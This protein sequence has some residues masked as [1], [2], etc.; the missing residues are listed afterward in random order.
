[1]PAAESLPLLPLR[2][3][4]LFPHVATPLAVGREGSRA[5]IAMASAAPGRNLVVALQRSPESDPAVLADLYRIATRAVLR[6]VQGGDGE[7]VTVIVQGMERVLLTGLEHEDGALMVNAVPRPLIERD[8]NSVEALRQEIREL[9]QRVVTL[10]HGDQARDLTQLMNWDAEARQLVYMLATVLTLEPTE[11]Q[12]LLE[13]D[14]VGTAMHWVHTHLAHEVQIL[15]IRRQIAEQTAGELSKE[16]REGILRRQLRTIQSQLGEDSPE[17]LEIAAL[18]ERIEQADLPA[19]V[20]RE[21]ERELSRLEH[22]SA[23]AAEYPMARTYI[24]LVAALPWS[25]SEQAPVDLAE[26]RRILD[27]DH[28]GLG[29]V[30]QRILEHLAVLRLNPSAKG[31]ILCLIGPPGVGKTSL[32]HSIARATGRVFERLS[33]G[34]VHDEAELRGHRRTYVG[35]MPGR[36]IQALRRAGVNNPVIMLDE[37]DKLG[38]DFRGD[39]AA[40]LL[41]ILD[42]EQNVSFRD[43][44]LDLP[45]DLSRVMFITTGNTTD[46]VP[47]AL[48][49]RTE[50]VR[51]PG[52]TLEEKLEIA[53]RYLVPRQL[54]SAGLTAESF[55]LGDDVVLHVIKRYTREAGVRQL[56]RSLGRIARRCALALAEEGRPLEL[57]PNDLTGVLGP[58]PFFIDEARLIFPPGVAPGLAW[59]EAGGEVL[60][61]EAALVPGRTGL[62]LTGQLG[63]VMQESARAAE[64]YLLSRA[65][66]LGIDPE[67]IKS[68]ATHVHVPA[69]AVPKDGPSAGVAISTALAS[70]YLNRP[71]RPDTAMTG[72]VTITGL[73]LPVGG[74]KEKL[75]AA[76][77]AGLRRVIL[78]R[79]NEPSLREIEETARRDLEVV[80]VQ[81]LDEVWHEAL[82]PEGKVATRTGE[83]AW[84]QAS[85]QPSTHAPA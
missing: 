42:P 60:Y 13:I 81:N 59:T 6:R 47:P 37:I 8:R 10:T 12:E 43:N 33:L 46:T 77:R 76:R 51:L 44:Y 69:G 67:R 32:G 35:A 28:Y 56:E 11:A 36:V 24:E 73:V 30:K 16:Q 18:R 64:T 1:M 23:A 82:L 75:L 63:E 57:T 19:A 4:V 48:L 29:D 65:A 54:A 84:T 80:L 58:E 71:A 7:A 2:D 50:V 41:E 31:P 15:E 9:L 20:R 21:A 72:E 27:E 5:A 22:M 55:P 83:R 45:F 25:K 38:R 79:A 70:L 34:G 68:S 66:E 3:A 62:V 85:H 40:A 14:D 17:Q 74:V 78:P 39:P 61:I 49:D 52:Y 26:A 53:R